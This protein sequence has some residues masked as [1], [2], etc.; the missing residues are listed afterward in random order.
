[1][2]ALLV[3]DIQGKFIKGKYAYEEERFIKTVNHTIDTFRKTGK[4]IVFVHHLDKNIAPLTPGWEFD[5]RIHIKSDDPKVW[6]RKGNAFDGTDLRKILNDHNIDDVTVCGLVTQNCIRST[7]IGCIEEGYKTHLIKYG[8]TNW[9]K[10]PQKTI[11]DV[12]A[13]LIELGVTLIEL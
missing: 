8:T 2:K 12:E 11:D 9:T 13:E 4:L 5:E 10:N 1:M 6:K 7:C 3:V